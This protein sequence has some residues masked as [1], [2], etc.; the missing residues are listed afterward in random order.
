M[1]VVALPEVCFHLIFFPPVKSYF[2]PQ[3]GNFF[4]TR[5]EGQRT[6]F[7]VQIVKS[8]EGMKL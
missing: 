8:I 1:S 6:S 4:L 7:T 5:I 3:Y 2:F